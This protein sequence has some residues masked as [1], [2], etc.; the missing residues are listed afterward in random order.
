MEE[1]VEALKESIKGELE[2]KHKYLL[3]AEKAIE[4]EQPEVAKLFKAVSYAEGIH[5]NNHLNAYN[6]LTGTNVNVDE[7]HKVDNDDLKSQVFRTNV[8]L[9]NSRV[10]ETFE[11]K[12]KYTK[13]ARLASREKQV[14]ARLSFSLARKAERNHAGI[15]NR[16]LEEFN[17]ENRCTACE[18]YICNNCGNIEL[19]EIPSI[20]PVCEKES[21]FY[22]KFGE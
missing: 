12:K 16:F 10:N 4:E 21:K 15:F 5:I 1:V 19:E 17:L 13:F 7:I 20:C 14:V 2:A 22:I 3:F 6:V 18:F 8:N 9:L 11:Y